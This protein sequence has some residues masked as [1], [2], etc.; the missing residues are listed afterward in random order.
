MKVAVLGG[1]MA[2]LAAAWVLSEDRDAEVTVYTLGWR[3]GGK[4]ASG[5]DPDRGGR[6]I[7]HGMHGLMGYYVHVHRLMS[8]VY[9]ALEAPPFPSWSAALRPLPHTTVME[10]HD[11]EYLPWHM[12]MPQKHG[13]PEDAEGDLPRPVE[14]L[15]SALPGLGEL[16]DIDPMRLVGAAEEDHLEGCWSLLGA[17]DDLADAAWNR[18][19]D[20][21]WSFTELRRAWISVDLAATTLR[22][23]VADDVPSRGFDHLDDEDLLDWL[24]R[25]GAHE[26]TLASGLVMGIYDLSFAYRDG[27]VSQPALAAGVGL[28]G[29][30]RMFL[31]YRGAFV[32]MLRAGMGETM[33]APLYQALCERGVRFRFFHRVRH[34][35]LSE[36]GQRVERVDLGVQARVKGGVYAPLIDVGGMPV[37]PVAPL[38][39][40]L[41]P[42]A[43]DLDH[44][45][46][47]GPDV[48]T[49][50]LQLGPDFDHVV[51]GVSLGALAPICTELVAV[52]EPWKDLL[53]HTGTVA[54]I[55][56]QVW[57]RPDTHTL[58]WDA[59]GIVLSGYRQPFGNWGDYSHLVHR[60]TWSDASR[61]GHATYGVGVL[62]AEPGA[63]CGLQDE[64]RAWLEAARELWPRAFDDDG[65]RWELLVDPQ[66]REGPARLE[67]QYVRANTHPCDLY[68]QSL[69][70]TIHYRLA[71]EGSGV[72]NLWLAGDWT[73]NGL[74][75][76]TMEAAVRSGERAAKGVRWA[77]ES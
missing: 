19:G 76:G 74:D 6:I 48:E 14:L 61:P 33:M 64:A 62:S 54:T 47:D 46:G 38:W 77:P 16:L 4:G 15:A 36:D 65:L 42:A 45:A 1:G 56:L 39:D 13:N 11:G 57:L 53:E 8:A 12:R 26:R 60:E 3:L 22:G 43:A 75:M 59:P 41:E 23:M 55:A 5:R 70:G 58:G 35:A 2:A 37:W 49:I 52:H 72:D 10:Y 24:R 71:P 30:L 9:E 66:E 44:E 20:A 68:V 17:I 73:R 34:L 51:L 27:D 31:T 21:V 67:A 69:P 40:Q 63:A 50:Q 25:H 7:E 28:K 29:V 32:S 18:L